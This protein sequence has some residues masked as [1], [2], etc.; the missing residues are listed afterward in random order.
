MVLFFSTDNIIAQKN[1]I[2]N[3][4]FS[5]TSAIRANVDD[6]DNVDEIGIKICKYM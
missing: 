3:S 2:E 6:V 4:L 5:G 1:L